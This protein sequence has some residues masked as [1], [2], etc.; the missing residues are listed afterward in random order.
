[1][2]PETF[3][4]IEKRCSYQTVSNRLEFIRFRG[5]DTELRVDEIMSG[6]EIG[7]KF[8]GG[9]YSN[10]TERMSY[11]RTHSSLGDTND[12]CSSKADNRFKIGKTKG[13]SDHLASIKSRSKWKPFA[14]VFRPIRYRKKFAKDGAPRLSLKR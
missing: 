12:K 13:A 8:D 14:S 1:M 9:S 11:S 10:T 3:H 5:G 7:N 4:L 6:G 2:L